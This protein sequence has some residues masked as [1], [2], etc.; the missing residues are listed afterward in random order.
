MFRGLEPCKCIYNFTNHPDIKCWHTFYYIVNFRE[1]LYKG[2]GRYGVLQTTMKYW[3]YLTISPGTIIGFNRKRVIWW[4]TFSPGRPRRWH[5]YDRRRPES[6][7]VSVA[8]DSF[9]SSG[10]DMTEPPRLRDVRTHIDV[11]GSPPRP[12][13][14][15]TGESLGPSGVETTWAFMDDDEWPERGESHERDPRVTS[16]P[17]RTHDNVGPSHTRTSPTTTVRSGDGITGRDLNP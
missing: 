3:K 2:K 17:S 4:L 5:F 11:D 6:R 15:L 16:T 9:Q 14:V 8:L 1:V 12:G 10:R 13:P 7:W